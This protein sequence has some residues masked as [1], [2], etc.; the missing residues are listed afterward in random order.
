[1][2]QPSV[3][4]VLAFFAMALFWAGFYLF[5]S[6]IPGI[7]WL[8]LAL[9]LVILLPAGFRHRRKVQQDFDSKN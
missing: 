4:S 1:M 8:I 7:H 9:C 3:I 2:N 6:D 5:A